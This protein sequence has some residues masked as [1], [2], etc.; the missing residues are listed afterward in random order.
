MRRLYKC[1]LESQEKDIKAKVKAQENL[2][3]NKKTA[4]ADFMDEYAKLNELRSKLET[5]RSRIENVGYFPGGLERPE[6]INIQTNNH[7]N[8]D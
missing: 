6:I 8:H 7:K 2:V 1:Q 3:Y 5:I 4:D